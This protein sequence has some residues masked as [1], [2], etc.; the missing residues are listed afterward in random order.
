[1]HGASSSSANASGVQGICP[2]GWHLPSDAEWTQLTDYVG[3]QSEYTCGGSSNNIAKALASPEEWIFRSFYDNDTCFVSVDLTSN[4]ATGF[5]AIPA[6]HFSSSLFEYA[7]DNAY[8][9]SSTRDRYNTSEVWC[10]SLRSRT[11]S[12]VRYTYYTGDGNS[13]RCLRD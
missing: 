8:F 11:A 12:V 7:G 1:M 9:W 13:V 3:S 4:N 5:S 6:G 10:R 2:V